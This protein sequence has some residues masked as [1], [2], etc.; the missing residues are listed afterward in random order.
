[1]NR[2]VLII[3]DIVTVL[4]S[5]TFSPWIKTMQIPGIV[6]FQPINTSMSNE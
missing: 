4:F 6:S 1:M 5:P 3:T 2:H